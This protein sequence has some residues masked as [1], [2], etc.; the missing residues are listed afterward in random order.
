MRVGEHPL[1]SSYIQSL[2]NDDYLH[3]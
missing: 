2:T 1:V 3:H